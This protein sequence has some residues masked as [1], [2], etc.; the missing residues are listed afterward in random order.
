MKKS[1]RAGV[2]SALLIALLT[3][4]LIEGGDPVNA[5]HRVVRRALHTLA[6]EESQLQ[7]D[8][9]L[10]RTGLL[11]NYDTLNVH[12][13]IMSKELAPTLKS[14]DVELSRLSTQI[15]KFVDAQA[16]LI[17]E[18]KTDNAVFQNS[19]SYF[20]LV[21][22]R[23]ISRSTDPRLAANIGSL[24]NAI[25]RLA[26]DSSPAIKAEA[27]GHLQELARLNTTT[28]T[29]ADRATLVAHARLLIMIIPKV[30]SELR[31]LP[32]YSTAASRSEYLAVANERWVGAAEISKI[33]RLVLYCVAVLFVG[34]LF[35]LNDRL[36]V[37][38]SRSQ[39]RADLEHIIGQASNQFIS[40]PP[41]AAHACSRLFD[42]MRLI[43]GGAGADRCY[44]VAVDGSRRICSWA[45][46]GYQPPPEWPRTLMDFKFPPLEE[47]PGK[48]WSD[49]AAPAAL[50]NLFLSYGAK[51]WCGACLLDEGKMIGFLFL[52]A[53]G[54]VKEPF[55]SS[56]EL[57]GVAANVISN[58]LKQRRMY[59]QR[60][61]LEA[62]LEQARRLQA[63][64]TFTS[65]VA[66]NF[67]NILNIVIGHA[68]IA[69]DSLPSD[70]PQQRNIKTIMQ[71][72]E[73]ARELV[74]Q[75]LDYGRRGHTAR[76]RTLLKDIITETVNHL[77][78]VDEPIGVDL[79][80]DTENALVC[81]DPSQIQ[82][83]IVNLVRNARQ[84]SAPRAPVY[85]RLDR[86]CLSN[87]QKLS[88]GKVG[89][90][91][92][93]LLSVID[94]GTGISARVKRDIFEPFF[95]T[96]PDGTGLGLATSHEIIRESAGAIDV[97]S[98]LGHGATFSVW[99]PI[100][101]D[102]GGPASAGDGAVMLVGSDAQDIMQDEEIFAALGYEPV[103]FS[104]TRGALEALRSDPQRFA[105]ILVDRMLSD[106]TGWDFAKIA[107]TITRVPIILSLAPGEE[108]DAE[109]VTTDAVADVIR[110]PWRSRAL[111]SII[112]H[113]IA[114]NEADLLTGTT[115]SDVHFAEASEEKE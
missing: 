33:F 85:I 75:I 31:Q 56:P 22:A 38:V 81:G 111:A 51:R 67:N 15:A 96:K 25:E 7:K 6:L 115:S 72:G 68:E 4:L 17:E 30:D 91:N 113:H 1:L 36:R 5:D 103:G 90:G 65:G 8:V 21:S 63:V 60:K 34:M 107:V 12:I 89:P 92:Y 49:V 61:S 45:R 50:K 44:V 47:L 76:H 94:H 54:S 52:E 109:E 11:T 13:Y 70:I 93:L 32:A 114:S 99:L 59:E 18:F 105:V 26:R 19:L 71:A 46:D 102:A 62:K 112:S 35:R 69:S 14:D 16:A 80:T 39:Q 27:S 73:R 104:H 106:M 53:C 57:L 74:S 64:G 55:A 23:A 3:W 84:A 43:G 40:G 98:E 41:E 42:A 83:V 37:L 82:Q 100:V 29:E 79:G 110:R 20:E 2:A 48:Y 97:Q 87:E 77:R 28:E 9:L 10:E 86:A 24:A 95:T 66:H 101:A 78:S 108:A 88:H 58:A